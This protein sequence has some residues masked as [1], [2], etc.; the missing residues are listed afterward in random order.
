MFDEFRDALRAFST[1]LD[2]DERRRVSLGMREALVH[3][4]LGIRDL[5]AALTNTE[6]RLT[7]E[8]AELD[9][10]RRRQ[11]YAADIGDTETVAIAERFAQQHAERVA[12]LEQKRMVQQH[13]L[14]MSEREYESMRLELRRALSGVAPGSDGA[15]VREAALG[16]V[17]SLLRDDLSGLDPLADVVAGETPA[18]PRRTRAERE[19]D[20]DAR[21]ADLKRKLGR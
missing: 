16:D 3:A 14:M 6:A 11:G 10:V 1:R 9:T 13:E 12:M 17:D 8:S 7:A 18:P 5:Q 20:A 19:A 21:L 2:P 15:G 4:K